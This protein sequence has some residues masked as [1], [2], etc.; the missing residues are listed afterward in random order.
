MMDHCHPLLKWPGGKRW[1]VAAHSH[2]LPKEFDRYIEPFFGGGSVFFHLKP[3]RSVIC[4]INHELI[5]VYQAIRDDWKGLVKLLQY[6]QSRH[7]SDYYYMVRASRPRLALNRAARLIYLNRTCFNGIYRVN[8]RGEFNVPKGTRD[9]VIRDSDNFGFASELFEN[10]DIRVSD[11]APVIA[12]AAEGDFIFADPP[13]TVRHNA[14]GFIKY[15]EQ[16]FSWEDQVRLANALAEARDRGAN[17][18]ATNA[19]HR[20]IRTLYRER[21]F[22]LKRVSRYSSM[23]ADAASRRQFDELIIRC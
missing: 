22:D 7:C 13:Y 23:S 12:E 20:S 14:N 16:L 17:I 5:A 1:F 10:A 18:V 6:H 15:N 4:D 9:T 8:L 2:V 21:G 3:S 19:N 11:F